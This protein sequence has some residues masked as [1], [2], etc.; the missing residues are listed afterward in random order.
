M[1]QNLSILS[2]VC[3]DFMDRP[4]PTYNR[5]GSVQAFPNSDVHFVE[6]DQS[7]M[8]SNGP[9]SFSYADNSMFGQQGPPATAYMDGNQHQATYTTSTIE[10]PTMVPGSQGQVIT[11]QHATG[12]TPQMASRTPLTHTTRTSPATVSWLLENYETSEGVSLPRSTLYNH[13]LQHCQVNK[14]DAVNAASFGKL[15]RSVFVGL[16]TRRLGTRGNSK[17]H[18]YGIRIKLNSPLNALVDNDIPGAMRQSPST[19]KSKLKLTAKIENDSFGEEQTKVTDDSQQN[20]NQQEQHQQYL[21]DT[22]QGLPHFKPVEITEPLPD[23]I[24]SS[25]IDIFSQMYH[26]HCQAILDVVVN[27]QFSMVE[28]LW[29]TFWRAPLLEDESKQDSQTPCQDMEERLPKSKLTLLCN[30]EPVLEF[31]K[32]ADHVL[33]QILVETLIPNVLRP[34]PGSLTSAIRNY[35]KCLESWLGGGL[36]DVPHKMVELKISTCSAFSQTLRRYTSLNHLAQAARAV[37]QNPQQIS[38]MLADL[39]RVD[40]VNV[41]EQASWVCQCDDDVVNQLEADFKETLSEQNSLEKWA[42]WLESVVN[43][44][45]ASTEGTPSYPKAAR[46]FLLKWSF[47]SSMV[48]RDLTLRSAASFGSFHLI[49]LL[50]DEYMFYLIEHKVAAATGKS[51]IAVM[52]EFVGFGN[53][54]ALSLNPLDQLRQNGLAGS[55][56]EVPSDNDCSDLMRSGDLPTTDEPDKKKQKTN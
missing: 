33:Y 6:G 38:Q 4:T 26:E 12:L 54:L 8:Y 11:Y 3:H 9:G 39:N 19:H 1:L 16:K 5:P 55:E 25:D 34:I 15:I 53:K 37:L 13:Y 27:L 49:R 48:I 46:Q 47:Y 10:S 28:A 2:R 22:S 30:Y 50:Y 17:Y 36:A 45:L 44:V 40:F 56:S 43:K 23:G 32:N 21:G 24:S 52:G 51:P 18:Y 41:Q 14:L 31:V 35:A 29:H 20:K 7:T 42:E